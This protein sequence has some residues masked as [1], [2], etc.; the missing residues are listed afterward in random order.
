MNAVGGFSVEADAVYEVGMSF[1]L[2]FFPTVGKLAA[3]SLAEKGLGGVT[4]GVFR[5][6][7]LR[8]RK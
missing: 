2:E 7:C 4:E 3:R 1:M 6:E 8:R 5:V